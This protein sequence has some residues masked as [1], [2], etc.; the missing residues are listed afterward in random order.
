MSQKYQQEL[1]L[2]ILALSKEIEDLKADKRKSYFKS[3]SLPHLY[4][5][6]DDTLVMWATFPESKYQ[7]VIVRFDG[8]AEDAVKNIYNIDHLKKMARRGHA[9]IVW[10]AGGVDWADAVVK[11]LDLGEYI[12][13]CLSKGDYYLDDVSDPKKWMGK[14]SYFTVD[15]ELIRDK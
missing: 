4:V 2:K 15:G 12:V 10:S 3:P 1:E 14:Y 7:N 13:A 9:V 11:A 8:Y 5:D 6:V